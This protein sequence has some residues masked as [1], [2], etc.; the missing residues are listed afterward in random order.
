MLTIGFD[1]S[2]TLAPSP[3]GIARYTMELLRAIVALPRPDLR[4]AVL[5]NSLRHEPDARHGFLFS[6]PRIEVIRR[7]LP[8]PIVVHGWRLLQRPTWEQITGVA[9]DVVHGPANY[10]PPSR[11]PV[12]V[13]VHDLGFLRDDAAKSAA[14]AGKYFRDAFPRQLPRV[15]GIITPS[16]FVADEVAAQYHIDSS[17]IT[18]IHSGIDGALFSPSRRLSDDQLKGLGITKHFILAV[19]D[20]TPR[21]RAH[22][23]PEIA[24]LCGG[25]DAQFVALGLPAE[26]RSANVLALGQVSDEILAGLYA[27]AEAMLLTSRE[28]GFGFPVLEAL[29]SGT[30]VVCAGSSSLPEI[31][32]SFVT[33]AEGDSPGAF[34]EALAKALA[35]PRK[36]AAAEH[37]RG[38]TWEHCARQVVQVYE[39]M[40]RG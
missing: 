18:A 7:K 1:A 8:G 13:T 40:A 14:L 24:E 9:C 6:D 21:K 38:F 31:G 10:I 27:S 35:Q 22:W 16:R 29:A 12:V 2:V 34:A 25:I 36:D 32:G 11:S 23:I 3:R 37:A 39:R 30:R 19:S 17:R 26:M 4:L 28:E 15:A 20:G 33:Y 5:L